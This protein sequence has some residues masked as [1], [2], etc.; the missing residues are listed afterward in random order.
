ML[1][2]GLT[3]RFGSGSRLLFM[4]RLIRYM[5]SGLH[6]LQTR[7]ERIAVPGCSVS[8]SGATWTVQP[9]RRRRGTRRCHAR[10]ATIWPQIEGRFKMSRVDGG[11]VNAETSVMMVLA[12]G[13]I[14]FEIAVM[15]RP[16]S[17]RGT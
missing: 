2:A 8:T 7:A 6:F 15:P 1:T 11:M 14:R 12:T 10:P 16:R 3:F 17:V 13:P 9:R 4:K 5:A